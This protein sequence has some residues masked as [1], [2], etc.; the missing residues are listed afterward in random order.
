MFASSLY[1]P[2]IKSPCKSETFVFHI[3]NQTV[4]LKSKLKFQWRAQMEVPLKIINVCNQ[5]GKHYISSFISSKPL[6]LNLVKETLNGLTEI[7]LNYIETCWDP[8]RI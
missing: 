4:I 1:F 5:T 6:R 2:H 3:N 8:L 7:N